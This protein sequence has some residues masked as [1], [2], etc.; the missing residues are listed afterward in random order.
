[1]LSNKQFR[2][3]IKSLHVHVHVPHTLANILHAGGTPGTPNS[4]S[5]RSLR[6][7]L[8]RLFS[9]GAKFCKTQ[10]S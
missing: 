10:K 4:N 8:T 5:K 9:Q 6:K 1:M 7:G 2:N 3:F